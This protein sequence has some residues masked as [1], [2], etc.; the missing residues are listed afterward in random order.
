FGGT[1]VMAGLAIAFAL[2]GLAR[3]SPPALL[4]GVAEV[5]ESAAGTARRGSVLWPAALVVLGLGC[6]ALGVGQQNPDY[7]AMTFFGGGGL[8][9]A[10]GILAVRNW[11]RADAG[12]LPAARGAWALV[13][14][15]RRNA[16]RFR[17]RSL[18]TVALL[19]AAT[20]LLVAVET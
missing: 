6:L 10:G 17:G 8:L 9:L 7:R 18:L 5:P 19:A 2:R 20:F 12:T 14:L 3:V 11:L 1:V 16:A 13:G 15:G 4:R